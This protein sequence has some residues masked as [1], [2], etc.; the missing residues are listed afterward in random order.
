MQGKLN[1]HK[2][3]FNRAFYGF[4]VFALAFATY[5]IS[6][7][8]WV[9]PTQD[10]P[11]GNI[12]GP[13][14][15]SPQTTQDGFIDISSVNNP[16][17]SVRGESDNGIISVGQEYGV[18]GTGTTAGLRG[19][20]T[21]TS[22]FG[23]Y[24]QA[25]IDGYAAGFDGPVII[26]PQNSGLASGDQGA[27]YYQSNNDV[28]KVYFCSLDGGCTEESDWVDLVNGVW[29][30]NSGDVTLI[31]ENLA[32]RGYENAPFYVN[33]DRTMQLRINADGETTDG[34]FAINNAA[35][36]TVFSVSDSGDIVINPGASI[37][38]GGEAITSWDQLFSGQ[39]G[40]SGSGES[41]SGE[42]G[43]GESGSGES[44]SGESGSGESGSGESGSGEG[45]STSGLTLDGAYNWGGAGAGRTITADAGAV[46][47]IGANNNSL[48][49][50]N[51]SDDRYAGFF[52]TSGDGSRAVYGIATST[53]GGA[54][55]Y[56][57]YFVS[58]GS[59]GVGVYGEGNSTSGVGVYG[60][61]LN[62]G[63]AGQFISQPFGGIDVGLFASG[64]TAMIAQ[65][66]SLGLD[67]GCLGDNCIGVSINGGDGTG[68]IG[69]LVNSF[70]GLSA[71]FM[72]QEVVFGDAVG[73]KNEELIVQGGDVY[74]QRN[75]EVDGVLCLGDECREAWGA[76][77]GGYWTLAEGE[78]EAIMYPN[79]SSRLLI[80]QDAGTSLISQY[81]L[82]VDS[83]LLV[84]HTEG[85]VDS[86]LLI[87]SS[88]ASNYILQAKHNGENS[89]IAL[90]P[91]GG[92]VTIG[93]QTTTASLDVA[94]NEGDLFIAG[95]VEIEG[96]LCFKGTSDCQSSWPGSSGGSSSDSDWAIIS[97]DEEATY[98]YSFGSN[99]GNVF[100]VGIGED[101]PAE[102]LDVEGA[103]NLGTT[104]NT[105]L[106]TLR[107]N[108]TDFQG[109]TASGWE[110]LTSGGGGGGEW[111]DGTNGLYYNTEAVIVGGDIAHTLDNGSFAEGGI[112]V[113]DLFVTDEIGAE[114]GL[115]SDGYLDVNG[116][117][118]LNGDVTLGNDST[119]GGDTLYFT[120]RIAQSVPFL[121]EGDTI[122][123][124]ET[125]FII[126]D[127]TGDNNI[128]F[129]DGS[130]TV[131][132]LT[133]ITSSSWAT[134]ANGVYNNDGAVIAGA[135]NPHTLG[136]PALGVL[137]PGDI[138]AEGFVGAETALSTDGTL[139]AAGTTTLNGDINLGDDSTPTGD[140][141]TF[142]ALIAGQYPLNFD[143]ST[144]GGN[145]T[146]FEIVDPTANNTITFQNETGT[147][148]FL[149]DTGAAW[150]DGT[151]GTNYNVEGVI[152]GADNPETIAH[153]GFSLGAG[154]LFVEDALGVEGTIYTDTSIQ[155][156]ADLLIDESGISDASGTFTIGSDNDGLTFLGGGGVGDLIDFDLGTF[157]IDTQLNT[158]GLGAVPGS[159]FMLELSGGTT[160]GGINIYDTVTNSGVYAASTAA[161]S[162][163]LEGVVTGASSLGVY[164]SSSLSNGVYAITSADTEAGLVAAGSGGETAIAAQFIAGSVEVGTSASP[165]AADGDGDLYVLNDFEVSGY[166]FIGSG[167]DHVCINK[168]TCPNYP[169]EVGDSTSNGNG[170]YV[171]DGG[172]WTSTSSRDTK[173]RF[174]VLDKQQVLNDILGLSVT[175][176]HYKNTDEY[177]IGPVAEDFYELFGT[178]HDERHLAPGDM[179]GVALLGIQ[180]MNEKVEQLEQQVADQQDI[181]EELLQRVEALE[182][183]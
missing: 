127:P 103:I 118:L 52:S 109:Y 145:Q 82:T 63:F 48:E 106:G 117:T 181:I 100:N 37:T 97:S 134:G 38:L 56:G 33:S 68:S 176:W 132:F 123:T 129:Q 23:I 44:G 84:G 62:G 115:A 144:A 29:T 40:S 28:N 25:S 105:N 156:G 41:G 30:N 17:I 45:G 142:N 133:D 87:D 158:A 77:G 141:L 154:D 14:W 75:L 90:N 147:V 178:G 10:P 35:N 160:H 169:F 80:G 171:T 138:F 140:I 168:T 85:T 149:S 60:Q 146:V 166:A 162:N 152:V 66:E 27:I 67:V 122:D 22:S 107:W 150:T 136:D 65:A 19:I 21:G 39:S 81:P 16:A 3:K 96:A 32:L 94:L 54:I 49:V 120:G 173:D 143:G 9:E 88:A 46:S 51:S 83:R 15:L 18:V 24:G 34:S 161:S 183:N 124:N 42:S 153:V 13:L 74:V 7:A 121:F 110:S 53:T 99:D 139:Y 8:E 47:I 92:V 31:Q 170:A 130:G 26:A 113:G 20:G 50:L 61:A 91:A 163:A 135:D 119:P 104:T 179:A 111:T 86:G 148:A 69:L 36:S 98:M 11:L 95:D 57:G 5:G 4:L 112:G 116:Y 76:E 151:N 108:G 6:H 114:T 159:S 58:Q 155:I 2:K 70:D 128:T 131:A 126:T 157:S 93:D 43:S 12:T 102:V 71:Q 59:S 78:T 64:S 177:H 137:T 174:N 164:G 165:A 55:N 180:A 182:N 89:T 175:G 72:G 101:T 167:D 79:S 125:A 1:K 73:E 172:T